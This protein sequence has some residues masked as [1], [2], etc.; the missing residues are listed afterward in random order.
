MLDRFIALWKDD[1]GATMAEYALIITL[2]AVAALGA[3]AALG[4]KIG[5]TIQG[6]SDRINPPT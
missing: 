1:E 2:V 3:W 5:T 4:G 6:T